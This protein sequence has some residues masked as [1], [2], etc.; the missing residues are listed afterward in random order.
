M[1][2]PRKYQPSNGCEG[3]WFTETYC[4]NCLHCDPDPRGEKQCDILCASMAFQTKDPEYPKEWIYNEQDEPVCTK[5]QKWDW[6]NDGDPDDD[7]NP[8]KPPVFDPDQLVMFSVAD[9]ILENHKVQSVK[10]LNTI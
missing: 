9:E 4:M 6:G 3:M 1:K 10:A 2:E 7:N 5:W 8:K